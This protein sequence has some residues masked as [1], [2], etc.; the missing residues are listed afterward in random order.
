MLALD[1]AEADALAELADALAE[2]ALAELELALALV[3]LAD[4]EPEEHPTRTIAARANAAANAIK[5]FAF[6][7]TF[8]PP[9]LPSL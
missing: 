4:P 1:D 7:I 6:F 3:E 8:L 5:Y 2:L 9:V